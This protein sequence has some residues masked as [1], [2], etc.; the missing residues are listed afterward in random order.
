MRLR[1]FYLLL[2]VAVTFATAQAKLTASGFTLHPA[3]V[4]CP[5]ECAKKGLA[6][7]RAGDA[8]N[9]KSL[10]LH[11]LNG[12]FPYY[13]TWRNGRCSFYDFFSTS[14]SLT[15]PS[16]YQ[17]VCKDKATPLAW[18][19]PAACA[20]PAVD[21]IS[22]A[23]ERKLCRIKK[24]ASGDAD[25]QLGTFFNNT[26]YVSAVS[27]GPGGASVTI[28]KRGTP[29][30]VTLKLELLCK[31][32]PQSPGLYNLDKVLES[33]PTCPY[34]CAVAGKVP[35]P[36]GESGPAASRYLCRQ[37]TDPTVLDNEGIADGIGTSSV[38]IGGY[39]G[40]YF[41]YAGSSRISLDMYDC[42]CRDKASLPLTW[43]ASRDC[44]GGTSAA[45]AV[46]LPSACRV[47]KASGGDWA[48][49]SV[50][51][52]ICHIVGELEFGVNG[53]Q[54]FNVTG[55]GPAYGSFKVQ[56]LC[57]P[58]N[59]SMCGVPGLATTRESLVRVAKGLAAA[60]PQL[61]DVRVQTQ[62]EAQ[63]W[64]LVRSVCPPAA[65]SATSPQALMAWIYYVVAGASGDAL[66][67]KSWSGGSIANLQARGMSVSKS[68]YAAGVNV[69]IA[70]ASAA[71]ADPGDLVFYGKP[72]TQVGMYLGSGQVLSFSG[73][74]KPGGVSTPTIH[75]YAY[76]PGVA[77]VHE[78][79]AYP[80]FLV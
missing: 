22:G 64:A 5:A 58:G 8:A 30:A 51:R 17:C 29:L 18:A 12:Y 73:L 68:T 39:N 16:N 60:K 77:L 36:A 23:Y 43:A 72:T 62:Y 69:P 11:I 33:L 13:G 21:P 67:G 24:A 26:C 44:V 76:M 3:L 15:F 53:S 10:C 35:I 74:G 41:Q 71:L 49:G 25:F 9:K 80:D 4:N 75:P 2:S 48:I 45:A 42:G 31:P 59:R 6:V 63:S 57:S 52:D 55:F 20:A 32:T 65:P 1:G 79:R 19:A 66:F 47:R 40:C 46:R 56:A 28:V 78:I 50:T 34:T 38:G 37:K 14:K 27:F 54:L 61:I 70:A 7:V